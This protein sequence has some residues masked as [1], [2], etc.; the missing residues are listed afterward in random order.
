MFPERS[1]S[2]S[3]WSFPSCP[4]AYLD[5]PLLTVTPCEENLCV[6]LQPPKERLRDFYE[7]VQYELRI[8]S[9][10][11]EKKQV[12]LHTDSHTVQYAQSFIHLFQSSFDFTAYF[13]SH[14]LFL[15]FCI[16]CVEVSAA[17]FDL[18]GAKS[19]NQ[20]IFLFLQKENTV[21][22]TSVKKPI[23]FEVTKRNNCEWKRLKKAFICVIYLAELCSYIVS[24]KS[25][26]WLR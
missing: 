14:A 16:D 21:A 4:P 1:L 6:D 5:P 8:N 22:I 25:P 12:L 13:C 20:S 26:T 3:K 10:S 2:E 19:F 11:G 18:Q 17:P 15:M 23:M 9:S 24:K 7:S